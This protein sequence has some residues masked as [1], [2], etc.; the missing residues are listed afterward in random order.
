MLKCAQIAVALFALLPLAGV[1]VRAGEETL[2][3]NEPEAGVSIR[4][5]LSFDGEKGSLSFVKCPEGYPADRLALMSA[6]GEICGYLTH[7]RDGSR[8]SIYVHQVG[9]GGCKPSLVGRFMLDANVECSPDAIPCRVREPKGT[10]V[11]RMG[12]AGADSLLNDA[13]FLRET[14]TLVEFSAEGRVRIDTLAPGRFRVRL[15]GENDG[16]YSVRIVKDYFRSRNMP[17]YRPIDRRRAPH[18]PTGW[19]AWNISWHIVKSS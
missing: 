5:R 16:E 3:W 9:S 4:G 14:D 6:R 10:R 15:S 18:A 12:T 1:H 13:I 11:F 2:S 19:M 17:H 7:Q 8:R